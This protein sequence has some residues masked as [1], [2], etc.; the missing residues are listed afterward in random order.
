MDAKKTGGSAGIGIPT[1]VQIVFIILKLTKCIDW[2]WFWVL[3]PMWI[4]AALWIVIFVII[5]L[6]VIIC[7]HKMT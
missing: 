7:N 5:I 1:V 6:I 3:S 4:G 2:S